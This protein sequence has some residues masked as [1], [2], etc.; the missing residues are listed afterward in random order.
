MRKKFVSLTAIVLIIVLAL[1]CGCNAVSFGSEQ[2][3]DY[4]DELVYYM[5]ANDALSVNFLLSDPSAYGLEN[6]KATLSKPI[7]N[8]NDY[9]EAYSA[10]GSLTTDLMR[11]NFSNLTQKQKDTWQLLMYAFTDTA[12]K[13]DYFYFQSGYLGS[14]SGMNCNLPVELAEFKFGDKTDIE[15]YISLLNQSPDAFT[16]ACDYEKIRVDNSYGRSDAIYQGIVD[17]CTQFAPAGKDEENFLIANFDTKIDAAEF[18]NEEEKQNFKSQNKTA[19][20]DK[21]LPAYRNTA[22]RIATLIGN[23]KNNQLGMSHYENGANYYQLLFSSKT[24]T[25]E[26]VG[27]AFSNLSAFYRVSLQS[28]ISSR[29]A[30]N[31]LYGQNSLAQEI[32]KFT[33]NQDLTLNSLQTVISTL[34]TSI[35]NDFPLLPESV[36]NATFSFVDQSLSEFYSPAAYFLSTVDS[37]SSPEIICIN[38]HSDSEYNTY[39]LLSHEGYPGHLL[40]NAYFKSTDIHP[41][42]RLFAFTGYS[43]GWGN[44]AQFFTS[45]YYSE[46]A[47]VSK[48]YA[49][50]LQN[51]ILSGLRISMIDILVNSNGAD[52]N[53]IKSF[54]TESGLSFN[55]D[56]DLTE[57]SQS[58]IDFVVE[59]PANYPAYYYG[60]YKM[61]SLRD[62]YKSVLG[63]SYTDLKFHT[64]VLEAGP[65]TFSQLEAKLFK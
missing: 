39:E 32:G 65:M 9:Y 25:T 55:N 27:A 28:F 29:D 17:Q 31:A 14:V 19:M 48:A 50:Y 64:A 51:K 11:F 63:T 40:Q 56:A 7:L 2:F 4:L 15:N 1:F 57:Y 44:Y 36:P 23:A 21:L 16:A 52:L 53:G 61:I 42:R 13:K 58:L 45:K 59:N 33:Q 6:S 8:E 30:Y 60:Y 20:C 37:M 35:A 18:L 54:V 22:A 38:A 47:K 41:V 62:R 5:L 26:S 43:E 49:L 46:D 12:S 24:S 34:K 3:D 10:Y